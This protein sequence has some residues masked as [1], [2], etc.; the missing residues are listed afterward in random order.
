VSEDTWG[1]G[2]RAG[3]EAAEFLLPT[4]VEWRLVAEPLYQTLYRRLVWHGS[5]VLTK[6]GHEIVRTP[7]MDSPI[8]AMQF[9]TTSFP[10]RSERRGTDWWVSLPPMPLEYTYRVDDDL[11][12]TVVRERLRLILARPG[13]EVFFSTD[14]QNALAI[15]DLWP[16]VPYTSKPALF[17]PPK[18]DED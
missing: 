7:R 12:R 3:Y 6:P 17:K 11:G 1:D 15:R 16:V 2:L 8:A 18:W 4:N 5:A 9:L 14:V 10:I 13:V